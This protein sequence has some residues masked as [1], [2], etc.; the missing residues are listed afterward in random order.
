MP[1]GLIVTL[2][3]EPDELDALSKFAADVHPPISL[4]DLILGLALMQIGGDS[5]YLSD[6]YENRLGRVRPEPSPAKK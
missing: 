4:E 3:L 1:N 6:E 5:D 2:V